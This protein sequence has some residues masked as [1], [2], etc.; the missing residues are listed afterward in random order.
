MSDCE[1]SELISSSDTGSLLFPPAIQKQSVLDSIS[2][3]GKHRLPPGV[4]AVQVFQEANS[5]ESLTRGLRPPV[6]LQKG[7]SSQSSS[8]WRR[9]LIESA[10]RDGQEAQPDLPGGSPCRLARSLSSECPAS[11]DAFRMQHQNRFANVPY[12]LPM[13]ITDINH[14]IPEVA[15]ILAEALQKRSGTPE[16]SQVR[17]ASRWGR[18]TSLE[19]IREHLACRARA[20]PLW[21]TAIWTGYV[22]RVL[23][24]VRVRSGTNP[25]IS[26]HTVSWNLSTRTTING[27]D[28]QPRSS[29]ALHKWFRGRLQHPLGVQLET[30]VYRVR[31]LVVLVN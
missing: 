30:E 10:A 1:L 28:Q 2:T 14:Q 19:P 22:R 7:Y 31:N 26:S 11:E 12:F 9:A 24:R 6:A 17:D 15:K 27:P 3:R 25:H 5:R 29:V 18:G 8:P 21:G 20:V 16:Q 13:R 4:T 23:A